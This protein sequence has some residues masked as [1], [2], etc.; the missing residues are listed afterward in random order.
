ML[1]SLCHRQVF[2]WLDKHGNTPV[3]RE[4]FKHLVSICTVKPAKVPSVQSSLRKSADMPTPDSGRIN[5]Q[6][7]ACSLQHQSS[8][9]FI[10]AA[11]MSG[12]SAASARPASAAAARKKHAIG[13]RPATAAPGM[14]CLCKHIRSQLKRT[15][16]TLAIMLSCLVLSHVK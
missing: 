5:G 16:W 3:Q 13:H 15:G 14:S 6:E 4:N 7:Y 9:C 8:T 11:S 1:T 12:R 2:A 10:P